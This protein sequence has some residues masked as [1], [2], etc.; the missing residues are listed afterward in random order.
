MEPSAA[1]YKTKRSLLLFVGCLLLAIFA[2]FRIVQGEQKISV[3]PFQLERPEFLSSILLVA[4]IFYLFQFSLQWAAQSAEVQR[5]KFH[6]IDFISSNTIGAVSV[7][8]FV[9]SAVSPHVNIRIDAADIPTAVGVIAAAFLTAVSLLETSNRFGKW[10]RRKTKSEDEE[11]SKRLA[12]PD[13]EWVLVFNPE[14]PGGIKRIS[15]RPDGSIGLGKNEHETT[16]RIKN[17]LL[18]ILNAQDQ[19]HSRFEYHP[20]SNSFQHTNDADTQ[21]IRSQRIVSNKDGI[22]RAPVISSAA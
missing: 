13:E 18:E 2:G 16:W 8:C 7:L 3:L 4:V 20:S 22:V 19:F 15:F 17:G 1:Y 5:N 21:S 14:N 11:L 10:V 12:S 6:R 9:W